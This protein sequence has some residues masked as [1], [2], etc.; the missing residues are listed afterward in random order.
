MK[1]R[2]LGVCLLAAA[3][4]LGGC[5]DDD[6]DN[7]TGPNTR[8]TVQFVN[9]GGTAFDV[10]T[11]GTFSGGNSN[12]T[13][14]NTASACSNVSAASP[15]LTFRQNGSNTAINF[16]PSFQG[17]QQYVVVARGSGAGMTLQ[18]YQNNFAQNSATQTGLRVINALTNGTNYQ[19]H[20]STAGA[21]NTT[22]VN[23]TF[24][25]GASYT[26]GAMAAGNMQV[27]LY[28]AGSTTP[29]F[30]TGSFAAGAGQN[31][32]LVIAD[33]ATAGGTP[34]FFFVNTCPTTAT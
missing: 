26:S 25:T 24:G 30:D 10:G 28:T 34:R 27:R 33:P 12:I 7:G 31:R 11:G 6:D 23:S 20:V 22:P 9:A 17:G 8:A 3:A 14:G 19:L 15:G 4:V 21:T 29:F 18:Q 16:T 32:T 13:Y 2:L 5:G 1:H